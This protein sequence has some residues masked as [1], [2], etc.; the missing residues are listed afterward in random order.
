MTN[1]G[2]LFKELNN[3]IL[4]NNYIEQIKLDI[5]NKND[6]INNIFNDDDFMNILR[7]F[8]S[9][10]NIIKDKVI[11]SIGQRLK[12]VVKQSVIEQ[13]IVE[14]SV[15]EQSIVEQSVV[16]QSV[17]EQSDQEQDFIREFQSRVIINNKEKAIWLTPTTLLD[18]PVDIRIDP[19]IRIVTPNYEMFY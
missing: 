9:D 14:Q 17:I 16:E 11:V 5:D 19:R 7:T 10:D 15:I 12:K 2:G 3:N 18:P 6:I 1:I 4:F 8:V 13:S